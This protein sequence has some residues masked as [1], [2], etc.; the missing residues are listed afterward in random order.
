[1]RV[2]WYWFSAFCNQWITIT[3]NE[4]FIEFVVVF[5]V[6]FLYSVTIIDF[7]NTLAIN[8]LL[9]RCTASLSAYSAFLV[10]IYLDIIDLCILST[11]NA[12]I[13]III[14]SAGCTYFTVS[15]S[16]FIRVIGITKIWIWFL[17]VAYSLLFI[18]GIIFFIAAKKRT[19]FLTMGLPWLCDNKNTIRWAF[20]TFRRLAR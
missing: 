18:V 11:L 14:V 4:I 5:F 9:I 15:N 19:I 13:V 2:S 3:L 1:M 6:G 17:E 16:N 20:Q 7:L 8:L 10:D 12:S